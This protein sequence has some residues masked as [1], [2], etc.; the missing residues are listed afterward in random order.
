MFDNKNLKKI[1]YYRI[2]KTMIEGKRNVNTIDRHIHKL[3]QHRQNQEKKCSKQPRKLRTKPQTK[4][5]PHQHLTKLRAKFKHEFQFSCADILCQ[6]RSSKQ[7]HRTP[8]IP[9]KIQ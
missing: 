3:E 2:Y 5:T 7:Q 1:D 6:T 4:P 9:M 8:Y